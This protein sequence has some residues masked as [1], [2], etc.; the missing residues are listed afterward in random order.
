MNDLWTA[1]WPEL[2]PV[3]FGAQ[4]RLAVWLPLAGFLAWLGLVRLCRVHSAKVRF[5]SLLAVLWLAPLVFI[6]V[7]LGFLLL[8]AVAPT[9]SASE[10][11]LW[12]ASRLATIPTNQTPPLDAWQQFLLLW[13]YFVIPLGMVCALMLGVLEYLVAS[14]RLWLLPKR[15]QG[16][17]F[18]LLGREDLQAFT[19]GLLRPQV[20]LSQALWQGPYQVHRAAVLAHELAHAARR[21]PLLLFWAR[22]IRR[23]TL[24]LPFGGRLFNDL[25]LEAE[26]ACD[27]AGARAVGHKR[28]AQALLAF[29]TAAH[30]TNK[31]LHLPTTLAFGWPELTLLFTL[32]PLLQL[33]GARLQAG[34][35]AR[36]LETLLLGT[37]KGQQL[38]LFWLGFGLLYGLILALSLS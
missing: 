6:T 25:Y 31:P 32:M 12:F 7:L 36:R 4:S 16:Q 3:L 1:L 18:V 21:D 23:S 13:P 14:I 28:Y 33:L 29:A 11:G 2:M 5:W 34:F 26:R 38:V 24:Y 30:K 27:E 15:R 20:Y 37:A 35:I 8:P 9:L 10:R 19:F 17:V 22:A